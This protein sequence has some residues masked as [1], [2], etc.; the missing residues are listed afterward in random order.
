MRA[1]GG[2]LIEQLARAGPW[3]RL[4]VHGASLRRLPQQRQE[5]LRLI[6]HLLTADAIGAKAGCVQLLIDPALEDAGLVGLQRVVE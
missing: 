1:A 3:R 5:A 2:E 4:D 6:G